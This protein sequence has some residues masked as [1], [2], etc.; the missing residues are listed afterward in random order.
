MTHAHR[1]SRPRLRP[2][3]RSRCS[4]TG[5][6]HGRRRRDDRRARHHARALAPARRCCSAAPACPASRATARASRSA[7]RPRC[8]RSSSCPRRSARAPRT[9]PT[10][11]S[12]RQ[13]TVGGNLCAG[14]GP[15]RRAATSRAR[16]SPSA[17]PSARPATARSPRSRSRSSSPSAADGCCSACRY[18]EP[19]AGAFAALDRPHTHDYTAL[20]GLGARGTRTARSASPRPG[21][22]SHGVRLPP[23]RRARRRRGRRRCG[24]ADVT[25]HDDALASAWYRTKMLPVLVRRVLAELKESA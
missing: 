5:R 18:D 11:R 24:A 2:T 6:R 8:R 13:G 25:L 21:A 17:R 19:A 3:R 4:A 15:T 20:A 9:S 22:G 12:A 23:P 7:R 1:G 14:E 10:S 16:S